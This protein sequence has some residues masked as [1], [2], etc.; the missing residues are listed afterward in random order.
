MD[1]LGNEGG[2]CAVEGGRSATAE[3]ERRNGRA[4]ARGGLSSYPV[5]TGDA[6]FTT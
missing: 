3:R 2:N 6:M 5:E 4:T 1:T